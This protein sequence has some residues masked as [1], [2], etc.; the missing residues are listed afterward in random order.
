MFKRHF[1]PQYLNSISDDFAGN[2]GIGCY[3]LLPNSD[4]HARQIADQFSDLTIK[5][6]PHWHNLYLG[7]INA[8]NQKI[9]VAVIST[10]MGC[11]S[12]EII[13][14]ELFHLGAKRFLRIGTAG[15]LQPRFVKPGDFI[16]AQAAI[17][18]QSNAI[19]YVP[20]EYPA[21]ASLEFTS[22][23]LLAAETLNL[24]EQ[25]HT[26]IVHCKNSAYARELSPGPKAEE[27][28][29][30][31]DVLTHAGALATEMETSTF[32]IQSQ[33]YNHKLRSN[34]LSPEDCVLA[35]AILG[36]N[37]V[38]DNYNHSEKDDSITAALA[39]I[40]LESIKILATQEVI[41]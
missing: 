25:L 19:H 34:G 7:N 6:H 32:F 28:K 18:D 33:I 4:A 24:S 27:N 36:I 9:D 2:N 12:I 17:R 26:G 30:Y 16:N 41:G 35:G 38:M 11:A 37:Y 23:I 29:S 1:K 40:A 39:E 21:V 15:S 31:M 5:S 20:I 8:D 13:L 14:H 3:V 22:S 10:G